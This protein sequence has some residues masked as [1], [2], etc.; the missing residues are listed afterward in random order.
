MHVS[1]EP[2]MHALHGAGARAHRFV[3]CQANPATLIMGFRS[4]TSMPCAVKM[5]APMNEAFPL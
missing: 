4:P 5:R 2:H 1:V 3:L